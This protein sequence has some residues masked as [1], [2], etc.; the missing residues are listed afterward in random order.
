M[1]REDTI[2]ITTRCFHGDPASCSHSCPFFFDVR[3]FL[4]RARD[5]KWGLAYKLY[6]NAT[7][8]PA[9]VSELCEAPCRAE[10]QRGTGSNSELGIRNY[11][12]PEVIAKPLGARASR[13]Q[14]LET[15]NDMPVFPLKQED[16]EIESGGKVFFVGDEP[17]DIRAVE[18]A[19]V[20]FAKNRKP[21]CYRIQP[22]EQRVAIIGAGLA[23]LSLALNLSQKAYPVTVFERGARALPTWAA[24]PK[25]EY[26]LEE[27]RL[28][29]SEVKT[30]FVYDREI[31]GKDDLALTGFAYVYDAT[32]NAGIDAVSAI[33]NGIETSKAVE[34]FLQ[35]GKWPD[36][37]SEISGGGAW[38]S[39]PEK[40]Y[41][42]HSSEPHKP[43]VVPV[44]LAAGYTQ[45]EASLEASRCM[46]C[47]C[48]LCMDACEMLGRYNKRPQKIAIE[49][50]SDTKS[51]PPFSSCTLTRE[52]YSCNLC[53]YCKSVCP[54][55]VDIEKLFHLARIGR[56]ETGAHPRAF[57]DFWMRD[58][59]WHRSEG[60]YFN[61]ELQNVSYGKY[62]F[63]PGCKLGAR[64]PSQVKKAALFLKERYGAG[65]IL[66]CCGAPAYWAGEDEIF[67]TH[68]ESLR[69][70]WAAAGR[71]IFVFACA[72]CMKLFNGFIPE[73]EKVSLYELLVENGLFD[74]D[75]EGSFA[76]FDPCVARDF[77]E[78]EKAVRELAGDVGLTLTELPDRNHCC[79]FGGHMRAA[80]QE[81]FDKIAEHRVSAKETPYL[82]YCAN[83]AETFDLTGKAH[84]HILDLVI[85]ANDVAEY[86][87]G[88]QKKRDNAVRTKAALTELYEG[89]SFKPIARP[90][91]VLRVNLPDSV[92]ADMNLRLI[93]TDD[94]KEAI[95]ESERT[96]EVFVLPGGAS[97]GGDLRQCCLVREVV[98]IW[99][100]YVKHCEGELEDYCD[101]TIVDVWNHRMRFSDTVD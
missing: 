24:H 43:I 14:I 98:T 17:V 68:I 75:G 44:D 45:E 63:F 27:I 89:G 77:P 2:N 41:V 53:G 82:V 56:A 100:Q 3:T 86:R 40:H 30:E 73:I 19:A 31:S 55:G 36:E 5:G 57:H 74:D 93:L 38:P 11:E 99:V 46:G 72:Y 101:Y 66:D 39:R 65:V 85:G 25:Y 8:F 42:D 49:A 23:G 51:A 15:T 33:A 91:D 78:M 22:R 83:C 50:Y 9:I 71:P 16:F 48:R 97:N 96:G 35:T 13:S 79:G 76:V 69:E 34:T 18:S 20:R 28:Q 54:V 7:V 21:E 64:S 47:D 29:F 61:Y 81:L 80:N 32:M 4:S 12:K 6:R 67:Q 1:K 70:K 95:Y 37:E 88:L 84:T 92:I 59:E 52:T 94:V 62:I 60:A 87:E 26:F 90:W 58:F 10:C